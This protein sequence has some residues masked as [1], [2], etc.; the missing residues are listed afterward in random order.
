MMCILLHPPL[1]PVTSTAVYCY[2]H[3]CI[4]SHPQLVLSNPPLILLHPQLH[5]VTS[6]AVYCYVHSCVL[7]HLQLC[8]VTSIAV[9]CYIH[10]CILLH[11]RLYTVTSTA[12]YC[13]IHSCLYIFNTDINTDFFYICI[14]VL[15]MTVSL[16]MANISRNMYEC[17]CML[18]TCNFFYIL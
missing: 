18:I 15:C 1:Y 6:T 11:P 14:N 7:L 2:I 16:E 13:Y 17:S 9:Y 4:L 10:S 3:G 8:T 12:V 5:I